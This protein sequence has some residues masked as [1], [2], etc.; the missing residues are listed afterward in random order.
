MNLASPLPSADGKKIFA[1]A[2]RQR[3]QLVRYDGKSRQFAPFL[4]GISAGGVDLSRDGQWVTYVVF[5]EGTLWRSK[6][7]GSERLQLTMPPME[8]NLPRWSPDGKRIAR[9]SA[10]EKLRN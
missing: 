2:V 5:P 8:V 3:G 9:K 1:V 6:V 4:S 10:T 7:N